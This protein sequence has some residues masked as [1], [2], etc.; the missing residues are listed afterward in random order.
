MHRFGQ[1]AFE[2]RCISG[3]DERLHIGKSGARLGLARM[4]VGEGLTSA[5]S[6]ENDGDGNSTEHASPLEKCWSDQLSVTRGAGRRVL[7]INA[8]MPRLTLLDKGAEDIEP[9]TLHRRM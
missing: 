8:A 9:E 3:G 7:V 4:L 5:H 6:Q 1:A 2:P